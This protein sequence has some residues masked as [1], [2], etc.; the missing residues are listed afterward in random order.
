MDR[1]EAIEYLKEYNKL[2]KPYD[3]KEKTIVSKEVV[4][5]EI[6]TPAGEKL[7][8]RVMKEGMIF[9]PP[10]RGSIFGDP[11]VELK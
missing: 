9:T 6:F 11:V 10:K 2:D 8:T 1:E 5:E 3:V 7:I 4:E